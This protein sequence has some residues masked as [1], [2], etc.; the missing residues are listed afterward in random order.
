MYVLVDPDRDA[1]VVRLVDAGQ[2]A[3]AGFAVSP[4]ARRWL[5]LTIDQVTDPPGADISPAQQTALITEL[6]RRAAGLAPFE[7]QIGSLLSY[8]SGVIADVHPDDDLA[9]LYAA[10][11]DG[12]HRVLGPAAA[13]YPYQPPHLSIGYAHAEGDSDQLQRLLRR[14]RPGHATLHVDTIHLVDVTATT[15]TIREITWRHLAAIRLGTGTALVTTPAATPPRFPADV[16]HPVGSAE[17]ATGLQLVSLAGRAVAARHRGQP[18]TAIRPGAEGA[19]AE[20][21]YAGTLDADVQA[22]SVLAAIT[23]ATRYLEHLG[24]D[25]PQNLAVIMDSTRAE[26]ARERVQVPWDTLAA[27]AGQ[28]VDRHWDAVMSLAQ[29]LA[30]NAGMHGAL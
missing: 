15:G 19:F 22:L 20:I 14:V 27:E 11:H 26:V 24:Q 9:E 21:R 29:R 23:A 3:A 25:D 18:I 4:V 12:I 6:Q 1:E 7:V 17:L 2:G 5:H 8:H 13:R 30:D 28:V 16:R 10:V